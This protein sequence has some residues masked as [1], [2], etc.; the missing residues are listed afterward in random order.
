MGA[1]IGGDGGRSGGGDGALPGEADAGGLHINHEAFFRR[2]RHTVGL[3]LSLTILLSAE[4]IAVP[5][6]TALMRA[7]DD[8]ILQTI[9]KQILLDEAMHIRFQAQNEITC[10]LYFPVTSA[11]HSCVPADR[12]SFRHKIRY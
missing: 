10:C 7:T 1:G 8:A 12:G 5:Y 4:L 11:A 3:R 9:C 6:Y 2:L